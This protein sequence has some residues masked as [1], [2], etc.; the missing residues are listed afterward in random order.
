MKLPE[1]PFYEP[2]P[3]CLK[4]WYVKTYGENAG[5]NSCHHLGV[6]LTETGRHLYNA[7]VGDTVSE[8][9]SEIQRLEDRV[10]DLESDLR[11]LEEP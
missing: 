11:L 4:D 3:I 1:S 8:L 5:C 7:L 10:Q 9:Q 6:V 2:C